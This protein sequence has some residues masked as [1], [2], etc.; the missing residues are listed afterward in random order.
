MEN[1]FFQFICISCQLQFDS[2]G[3]ARARACVCV[4]ARACVF[5][6]LCFVPVVICPKCAVINVCVKKSH[7]LGGRMLTVYV[8]HND[9]LGREN[10]RRTMTLFLSTGSTSSANCN[11]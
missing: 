5:E 3:G 7:V 10:T 8:S 1:A 11:S 6:S 4:S 9:V 2:S